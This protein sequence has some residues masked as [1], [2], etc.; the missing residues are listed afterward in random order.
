MQKIA[1]YVELDTYQ[2][3][4]ELCTSRTISEILGAQNAENGNLTD[5]EKIVLSIIFC[6]T[7]ASVSH[8]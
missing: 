3:A 4:A 1:A 2:Y 7:T 6:G 5:P 8:L